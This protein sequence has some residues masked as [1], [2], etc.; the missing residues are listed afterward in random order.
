MKLRFFDIEVKISYLFLIMLTFIILLDRTSI[1]IYVILAM[2]I[3]ECGH[4][5]AMILLKVKISSIELFSSTVKITHKRFLPAKMNFFISISGPLLNLI[6]SLFYFSENISLKYFA[7]CNMIIGGFNLLPIKNLDG[8]DAL[9][10]L[11][12]NIKKF[13][14]NLIINIISYFTLILIIALGVILSIMANGNI[15][16][17]LASIYLFI[18]MFLKV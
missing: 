2:F 16:L 14:I 4:L 11:L 17:L 6:F 8:G 10:F 7:L 12:K 9:Y 18:L 5:L 15:T 3:H 13:K 1:S